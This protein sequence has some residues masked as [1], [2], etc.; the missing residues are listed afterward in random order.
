MNER[1]SAL[2]QDIGFL[3]ALAVEGR[4]ATLVGGS[5][6]VAAGLTFAAASVGDWAAETG[7]IPSFGGWTFPA[8]WIAAMAAFFVEFFILLRRLGPRKASDTANRAVGVAWSSTGATIFCMFVCA[9]IIGW[10]THTA[11]TMLLMP[12][13]VLSLYGLTWTVAATMSRQR[14]VWACAWGSYAGAVIVAAFSNQTSVYLIFA[15]ALVLLVAVPGAA[16]VR[17]ARAAA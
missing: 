12:S 1:L 4:P 16:M 11:V 14:W 6:L 7:L 10:R 13:I 5:M 9:A 2:E 15:A 8:I 3:K 17:Q